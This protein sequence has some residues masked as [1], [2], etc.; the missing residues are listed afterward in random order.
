MTITAG[1]TSIVFDKDTA[2]MT[3]KNGDQVVMQEKKPLR[4]ND[5]ST[6]QTLVKQDAEDFFGGGTQNGRFVHTG[7]SINIVN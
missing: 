1:T 3:V 4:I 7:E 5:S 2:L 6:V